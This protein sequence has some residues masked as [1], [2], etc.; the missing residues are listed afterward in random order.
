MPQPI[1]RIPG[2]EPLNLPGARQAVAPLHTFL[3][4][5]IVD[6]RLP[7]GTVLSQV[8]LGRQLG[9]SRTPVREALRML[10]EEGFV[11]AE[12]NQRMRV[13]SLDPAELDAT[14]AQRILLETL[15]LTMTFDGFGAR[16]RREAKARVTAM[17]RA[18]RAKD[19]ET[20][21]VV[22]AEYHGLLTAR[23]SEPLQR[24]LRALSDRSV[25][26]IRI[27]QRF[28]PESWSEAG[29]IE[30]PAILE[31]VVAGD[32][33]A[34][35]SCLAHHLERTALRVMRDHAPDHVP[36]A[37]QRAMALVHAGPA[38]WPAADEAAWPGVA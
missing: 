3:R 38:P 25:R 16:E 7:P 20:W 18:A 36:T 21:F 32:R 29:D 2:I 12:P 31:A 14:Y 26:Y 6:G 27:A 4:E 28:D 23:A 13:A 17:R 34:A 10:Q 37:V 30:H 15:A 33:E 8:A 35:V 11:E 9:V 5:C 19:L 1:I 22:H 24:Q